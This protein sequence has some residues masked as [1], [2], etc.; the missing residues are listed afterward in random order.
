GSG[1]RAGFRGGGYSPVE[2]S[3]AGRAAA[4]PARRG[5]AFADFAAFFE[6]V[7]AFFFAVFFAGPLPVVLRFAARRVRVSAGLSAPSALGAAA[8]AFF[9]AAFLPRARRSGAAASKAS[10]SSS[11]SDFGSRS[12]GIFAFF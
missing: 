6:D 12:F 2:V 4:L 11:V 5:D 7:L 8:A 1:A 10:H 9:F 3:P